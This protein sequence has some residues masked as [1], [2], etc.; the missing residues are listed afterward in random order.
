MSDTDS[1]QIK[2]AA[3][4]IATVIGEGENIPRSRSRLDRSSFSTI[5]GL[6]KRQPWLESRHGELLDTLDICDNLREQSLLCDLIS[7]FHRIDAQ[8]LGDAME[9]IKI[10]I[11]QDWN[12]NSGDTVVAAINRKGYADSSQAIIWYL[13]PVLGSVDGWSMTNFVNGL[14]HSV[15]NVPDNGNIVVVDEFSGSGETVSKAVRWIAEKLL[16]KG[17]IAKIYVCLVSAMNGARINIE[18]V[19]DNYFS[20]HWLDRG[21]TDFY[22]GQEL[23]DALEDMGKLESKLNERDGN[24]QLKKHTFG[25]KKTES[26]YCFENGNVPNNVFPI[27]WWSLLKDGR[28]RR[29]LLRRV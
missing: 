2:T 20:V 25:Y 10:K 23:I 14:S 19:T 13:K 16:E 15:E 22:K 27:F 18:G 26:I 24:L 11:A 3:M 4:K 1:S 5:V 17:K 9:S 29:P 21:I 7:R 12:L 28:R 6:L 8:A